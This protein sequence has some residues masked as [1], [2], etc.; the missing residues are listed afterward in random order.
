MNPVSN[1]VEVHGLNKYFKAHHA[2]ADVSFTVPAG[3]SLGIV[4]ES[5]SGK[6]TIAR[7]L[8]GLERAGSGSI[9]VM[10]R[11]RSR[12]ARGGAERNARARELQI[13]FQDPYTSLDPSQSARA[14]VDEILRHHG[15]LSSAERAARLDE[16]VDQVGLTERQASARPRDLSGGQRQRVAIARAL[17]ARPKVLVLDEA[18]SAL[19]VSI[20]AQILNLLT[21]IR[22]ETGLAY[23]LISHDLAVVRQLCD[24]VLVLRRGRVVEQGACGPVLDDPR[25]PYTRALREAVPVPGWRVNV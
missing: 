13:V 11:D 15:G 14:A 6:T 7:M 8:V 2:V 23:L 22:A 18:V 25:E 16:L 9:T 12:P 10:G 4:G 24:T 19:D 21:D 3:G 17:A 1:A 20:Q 5:G